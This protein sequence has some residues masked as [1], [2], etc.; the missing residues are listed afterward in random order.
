MREGR[1]CRCGRGRR[2]PRLAGF[3]LRIALLCIIIDGRCASIFLLVWR[4]RHRCQE[5]LRG[6]RN[7]HTQRRDQSAQERT[8]PLCDARA[9]S[10]L[11]S[12]NHTRPF[13]A[14][15]FHPSRSLSVARS[16][17]WWRRDKKAGNNGARRGRQSREPHCAWRGETGDRGAARASCQSRR[18][19]ATGHN[20]IP[21]SAH[22]DRE[23][24]RTGAMR[25]HCPVTAHHTIR[26]TAR[27]SCGRTR[28]R[29]TRGRERRTTQ[30]STRRGRS[31]SDDAAQRS[32]APRLSADG[33]RVCRSAVVV[34]ALACMLT[35]LHPLI[36]TSQSPT[37]V[38][39]HT[40]SGEKR[41]GGGRR[42]S[43]AV[44]TH[45]CSW[46]LI[47]GFTLRIVHTDPPHSSALRPRSVCSAP[48]CC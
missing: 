36:P 32:P 29:T 8:E 1:G 46:L 3:R 43:G 23:C 24:S 13:P 30:R 42:A 10:I 17:R 34:C 27:H 25:P 28:G 41:G 22:R 18:H 21:L 37:A 4:L 47:A 20:S 35:P 44:L 39:I 26:T 16:C 12:K 14:Q 11:H 7:A 40:R 45:G 19:Q 5:L 31:R 48:A 9:E 2:R 33:D 15:L 38:R 6:L